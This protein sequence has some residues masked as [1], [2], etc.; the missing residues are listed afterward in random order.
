MMSFRADDRS[1][2]PRQNSWTLRPRP[3]DQQPLGGKGNRCLIAKWQRQAVLHDRVRQLRT[4]GCPHSFG[5]A[6]GPGGIEDFSRG[7]AVREAVVDRAAGGPDGRPQQHGAR[8][9]PMDLTHTASVPAAVDPTIQ[10]HRTIDVLHNMAG[11]GMIELVPRE[12]K[13]HQHVIGQSGIRHVKVPI[14][15]PAASRALGRPEQ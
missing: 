1:K 2:R 14:K 13:P 12:E 4:P 5:V 9:L 7:P 11:S 15:A 3:G 8:T 10:E 6:A